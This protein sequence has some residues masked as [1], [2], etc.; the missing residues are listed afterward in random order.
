MKWKI[1]YGDGTTFT[2]EDCKPEDVPKQNA[3]L[4]VI[5]DKEHGRVICKSDDFYIW[6]MYDG[7]MSWQGCDYFGYVDYMMRPGSKIVLFGRTLGNVDYR[8]LVQKAF[9]DDYLPQKTAWHVGERHG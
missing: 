6:D 4:V 3:Q 9:D 7:L 5:E 8:N 2:G 1:W